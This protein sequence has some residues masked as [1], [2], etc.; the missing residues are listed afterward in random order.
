MTSLSLG[1]FICKMGIPHILHRVLAEFKLVCG[2]PCTPGTVSGKYSLMFLEDVGDAGCASFHGPVG[3]PWTAE[4]SVRGVRSIEHPS[5]HMHFD[6]GSSRRLRISHFTHLWIIW[7]SV[8]LVPLP[9]T[10]RRLG[11]LP[12]PRLH[13]PFYSPEV[14]VRRQVGFL[15]CL[16][17]VPCGFIL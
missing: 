8:T 10:R 14:T 1:F 17:A 13:A 9:H 6:S 4:T 16:G 12:G 11:S 3:A 2:K 7:S 5:L 15:K